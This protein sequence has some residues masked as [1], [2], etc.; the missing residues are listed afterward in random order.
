MFVRSHILLLSLFAIVLAGCGRGEQLPVLRMDPDVA[1]RQADSI[2]QAVAVQVAPG[3]GYALWAV[4]SLAPDPIALHIDDRGRAYITRTH[5]QKNSE[6]DIRGYRRWMTESISWQTVDD[7]RAFLRR[8]F[9]PE[10]SDSNRWLA[11]LNG[12]SLHDWRDLA[13]EQEEVYRIED[14]SGD[15]VADVSRVI[16]RD[17][18]DEVA[19]IA[20]AFLVHEDDMFIGVAP[21]VWRL[22]DEDGDGVVDAKTSISEGYGVHIG[23]SGHN[24]SGLTVGPDGRIYWS[25]GDIGLNVSDAEGNRWSYPNEGAILRANPDG[26]DFEVF[27]AGL[28]NTHEF[29]FDAYGNLISVD[30]D[31]DHAGETERL[32]YIVNGS[33]SG[34]RANWQYGKYTDPRNNPYKVWMDEEMFRPRFEGQTAYITPPVAAYHTGPAGMAYNPGTAL[35]PEWQNTF[36]VAEFTGAPARSRVFG[37]RLRPSGASFELADDREVTRGILAVGMDFGPDGALYLADWIEGWGTKDIGRIW[38]LD[39]PGADT[40]RIRIETK[41]LL[42]EDLRDRSSDALEELLHHPDLRVRPKAQFALVDQDAEDVLLR[43]ARQTDHAFARL[44]GLWGIWQLA[45]ED[46]ARAQSL[47]S[48]L[49]DEDA[50]VRAQAAKILGD[51]RYARAADQVIP[52][53]RDAAPRVRFFAAEALGRMAH[54]PAVDPIIEMLRLNDDQDAYLRHAGALALA[55]I[56]DPQ[57]ILALATD[58]SRAIRIAAV[59]ALRRMRHPGV[60]R[61]LQDEDAFIVTEAARAINDDGGIEGAIPDLAARLGQAPD[62]GEALLRRVINANL[63]TGTSDAAVRLAA[64]AAR[65]DA[66]EAMRAEALHVLGVWPQPS[67]MDRVDGWYLGPAPNDTTDATTALGPHLARLLTSGSSR[68]STA[69]AQAAGMLRYAPAAPELLGRVRNDQNAD[70]QVA[71]LDA[72]HAMRSPLVADAVRAGLQDND[73]VVRMRALSFVPELQS[74]D[75]EKVDLLAQ[76]VA[77]GPALEQ[78]TAIRALADI[79]D[80]RADSVLAQLMDELEAGALASEIQLEVIEAV[81]ARNSDSLRSRLEAYRARFP[82]GDLTAQ[83]AEALRGGNASAGARIFYR[84]EAAQCPRC[85]AIGGRGGDVGPDLQN[86]GERLSREELLQSL[87]DPGARIAEG[88]G[89]ADAASAMPPMGLILSRRQIRDMVEFLAE[90]QE[91]QSPFGTFVVEE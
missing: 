86:V 80:E 21:H 44:H 69:T 83:Y 87:V 6:F 65:A 42:A 78:Q 76:I 60:A 28:R 43:T 38:K 24:I 66:P 79:E 48:F 13:V 34:W 73:G 40:T 36:F 59:V 11:D 71:A 1:A 55:R 58:P 82:A 91:G 33:D 64:Y 74:A 12:D 10:R 77:S 62:Q 51:L 63:R 45:R 56:G 46:A 9:A 75:D 18:N 37:F 23:F 26:S 20:G 4:D 68:I 30:N 85:H 41:A 54:R 17:F 2:R 29:V 70:V 49:V 19:D 14:S 72:L 81:D 50:E 32:V 3:L 35:G 89:D 47:V 31:G 67:V 57:P 61:F 52:L 22:H 8:E 84:H 5:R 53:L 39:V 27:A 25:I 90:L 88:Y 16:L 15:G 7:R